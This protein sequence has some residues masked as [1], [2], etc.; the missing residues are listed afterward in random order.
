MDTSERIYWISGPDQ[1][2]A[3]AS[4]VRQEIVDVVCTSGPCSIA[5][6][7]TFLGRAP[8]RLYYHVRMLVKVGLLVEAGARGE[9]RSEEILYRT[10]SRRM[11][12]DTRERDSEKDALF[13]KIV[14]GAMRAA[15]RDLKGALERGEPFGQGSK[16]HTGATRTKGWL[17]AQDVARV[18]NLID[19]IVE[20]YLT[21]ERRPGARLSSFTSCRSRLESEE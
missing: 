21:G 17:S 20:I 5:E 19:E 1:L 2:A 14:S 18:N 16:T 15:E 11:R 9:G 8:N 12:L 10:P 3:L 7:G 4:S 6:L 13:V